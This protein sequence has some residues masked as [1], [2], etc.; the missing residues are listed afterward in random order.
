MSCILVVDDEPADLNLVRRALEKQDHHVVAAET[1]KRAITSLRNSQVDVIVLDMMLPDGDG[2]QVLQR[3]REFDKHLPVDNR[4]L[5]C[6]A[7]GL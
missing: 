5:L 1:A 7:G 4:S 3:I 2:L 6:N